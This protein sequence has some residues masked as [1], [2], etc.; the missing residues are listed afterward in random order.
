VAHVRQFRPD[1]GLGF[2]VTVLQTL[3]VLPLRSEVESVRD[4]A[5]ITASMVESRTKVRR[6]V[7]LHRNLQRFGGG[8]V[9]KAHKFWVSLKSRLDRD[10]KR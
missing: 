9:V 7:G 5:L 4:V 3:N 8:L 2:R 1:S 6:K 10:K